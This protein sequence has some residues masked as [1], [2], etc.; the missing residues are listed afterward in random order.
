MAAAPVD[1][2]KA[3]LRPVLLAARREIVA[4]RD[5]DADDSAL[6]ERVRALVY[7]LRLVGGDTVAAYEALRTEP[8]TAA[9]ISAL[10][11]H[12]IRVLVPVTLPDNDLDWCDAADERRMPLGPDSVSAAGLVL[13]PGLAADTAGTR[14]GRGGGSYDRALLRR[15]TGARV[16]VVLHPGELRDAR[17]APLPR[18]GHDLPVDG[19]LTV[20]GTTWL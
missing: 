4:A 13:A 15:G 14:L 2:D 11:T 5:R 7:E 20:D 18:D 6:A 16:V 12:G 19:V 9:T 3:A 8:P 17:E 10:A 1:D